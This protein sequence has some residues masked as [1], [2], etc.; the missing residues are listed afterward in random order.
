M[1]IAEENQTYDQVFGAGRAP[2]LTRLAA[3]YATIADMDAGYPPGCPSLP[4]Y[5]LMT[6]GSTHG[7]CDDAGPQA[8]PIGGPSI[9]STAEAAGLQWR[10]YAESMPRP[11]TRD[12]AAGGRYLVRH[13]PAPYYTALAGRCPVWDVPLGT[14][15]AGALHDDVAAG[16]LPAYAFVTPDACDDMHGAAGCGGDLVATGDQWLARWLPIILAGPDYRAGRLLIV[17]TWDEGS[18]GSNHIPT[19]V[20]G[21]TARHARVTAPVTH[22]GLLAL[23]ERILGLPLLGCARTASSPAASLGLAGSS[24]A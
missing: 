9:F 24:A 2:F 18:A 3:Q 5:L 4:A 1:V 12:N 22:C 21:P 8:H 14:P 15:A 16:R 11:C 7:V 20:V 13:T 19:V 6:S 17:I 23:E 10:A